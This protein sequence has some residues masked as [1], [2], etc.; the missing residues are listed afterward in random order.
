MSTLSAY[1][2]KTP[3]NRTFTCEW[4]QKRMHI[5]QLYTKLMSLLKAATRGKGT[6]Q[7]APID[8]RAAWWWKQIAVPIRQNNPWSD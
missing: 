2:A 4:I 8:S 5:Y 6:N 3:N 1:S 7:A